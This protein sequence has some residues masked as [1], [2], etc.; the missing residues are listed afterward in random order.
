MPPNRVPI[1]QP[2]PLPKGHPPLSNSFLSQLR[3]FLDF[4]SHL[5]P[6]NSVPIFRAQPQLKRH[7]SHHLSLIIELLRFILLA[8]AELLL[9]IQLLIADLQCLIL[10]VAAEHRLLFLRLITAFMRQ[11]LPFGAELSPLIL[12]I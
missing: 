7:S 4:Q 11:F 9:L 5:M 2:Q 12:P 1:F 3:Y 6:A 10:L 8:A